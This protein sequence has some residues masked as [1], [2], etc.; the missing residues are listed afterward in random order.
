[1]TLTPKATIEPIRTEA[2]K[3]RHRMICGSSP[4]ASPINATKL[5]VSSPMIFPIGPIRLILRLVIWFL[6]LKR[7]APGR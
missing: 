5:A 1:M 6:M 4:M 7:I 2:I 3:A